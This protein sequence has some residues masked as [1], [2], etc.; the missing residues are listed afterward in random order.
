MKIVIFSSVFNH[1]SMPLCDALNLLPD[2]ECVFVETME[3]EEE[4]K[5]LGYH[6][7]N[8]DYVL[9]MLY[10]DENKTKAQE[11]ALTADVMIA[12][13]FP[14]AFLKERLDRN[15][16]TFLCQ[17]RMFKGGA[18]FERRARAWLFNMRKF[19]RFR[20][21]PLYFLSIGKNA[22]LDYKS[23]GFYKNKCFQ[24]AYFP[25]AISYDIHQLMAQKRSKT[26]QILF[27]GR[28]I[29]WKH[30]EYP[31][32]AVKTLIA[33]GLDVHLTYVGCGELE[34]SLRQEAEEIAESVSFLG[35]KSPEQVR[36]YMEKAN[37]FAFTSNSLEGWG[38]VLN[39]AMN[40]GCAVVASNAAGVAVTLLRDEENGCIYDSENY[41]DFFQKIE[42]LVNDRERAEKLGV[43][44]YLTITEQ[45]NATIAAQRLHD[46]CLALLNGNAE[47]QYADGIMSKLY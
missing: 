4:R 25:T 31:L 33:K 1:H 30:P 35:S 24:W 28:L 8:R 11:L 6:P 42:K 19:F 9:N 14:Y 3:E 16:L 45:Y 22:A 17:E 27:A 20:H 21:K 5:L 29:P 7:Y 47:H 13:V 38:A 23:I 36:S 43:A 2:V 32:R 40:S 39:E 12:G 26:V 34:N 10:S 18:T 15:K 37:I 46:F 41:S 44:A